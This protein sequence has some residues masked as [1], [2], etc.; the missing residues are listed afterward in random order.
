[1]VARRGFF[2]Y[3]RRTDALLEMRMTSGDASYH[4]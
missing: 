2:F 1:M 4:A 3:P